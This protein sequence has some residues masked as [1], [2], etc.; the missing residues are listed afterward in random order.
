MNRKELSEELEVS[1][2]TI[3]R[4]INSLNYAGV[5]IFRAD[6]GY[7]IMPDFFLEPMN[8][9]FEETLYLTVAAKAFCE[10]KGEQYK[11]NIDSALLKIFA[12]IPDG[13][14]EEIDRVMR[15]ADLEGK[16]YNQILDEIEELTYKFGLKSQELVQDDK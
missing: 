15:M 7:Q 4:D 9:N 12:S 14:R 5:P 11:K 8:L 3:Q 16:S 13:I 10:Y 1:I 2:R 6:A